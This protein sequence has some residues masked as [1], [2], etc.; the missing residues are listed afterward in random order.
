[1]K[2][3]LFLILIFLAS[4]GAAQGIHGPES[5]TAAEQLAEKR[6]LRAGKYMFLLCHDSRRV[7]RHA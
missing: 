7:D 1:M 2:S 5:E 6:S 4:I 3:T